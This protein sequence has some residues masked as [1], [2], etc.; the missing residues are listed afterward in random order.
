MVRGIFSKTAIPLMQKLLD[1]A[2]DRQKVIAGNIANAATPGY[3]RRAVDFKKSLEKARSAANLHGL[4]E[5]ENHMP[6]GTPDKSSSVVT[7]ENT[8]PDIETEMA[9]S[10]ENQ[11]L[12][13]TA[14]KIVSG[15]FNTI[16]GCIRGRF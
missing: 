14:V 3:Q 8:Q 9:L 2:S 10:A 6:L 16:K 4:V 11:I 5:D 7:V 13:A 1:T 12:Y 15:K